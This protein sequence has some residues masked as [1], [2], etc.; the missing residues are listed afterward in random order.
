MRSETAPVRRRW[1]VLAGLL[2]ALVAGRPADAELTA[3]EIEIKV[4]VASWRGEMID[5]LAEWVRGNTGSRNLE[6]LERFATEL[7]KHLAPLGFAVE[8]REGPAVEVP[9]LGAVRTGPIVIARRPAARPDAPHFLL[10]GHYDTVFEPSSCF[11]EFEVAANDV[12]RAHGPGVAD[13]KGGLVV[14][15]YA[16]RALAEAGE[17]GRARWTVILNGDEET[18]SLGSRLHIERAARD[19]TLGFVFEA[20]RPDG[21]MVRSRRGLG[22]FHYRVTGVAAHAGSAH[23]KGRSAVRALADRI[24]RLE[25]L[26]D[27]ERGITVN[28]G[29]IGGGTKRNIVPERAHAWIDIRYDDAEAGEELRRRIEELAAASPVEGT[30]IEVWG[31][32]HRPPKL[33]TEAVAALLEQHARV[34]RD[35]GLEPPEPLHSGGG[36]DG[37]LMGAVG[38]PTLDTMGVI[39][40]GAHTDRE[41][42]ELPSLVERAAIGAILLRRLARGSEREVE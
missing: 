23:A 2:V 10:V 36:T 17:L 41:Y 24:L 6:G 14:L 39:G 15:L 1:G 5:Q 3:E 28:V 16:L 8:T 37:S 7:P 30:E 35:F 31:T 25:E 22:Q 20:A 18:G 29:T 32:L 11:R 40:G 38:L 4:A 13:M 26:T 19:A 33:E 27:Y 12:E 21:A 34:V 9:G 42:V